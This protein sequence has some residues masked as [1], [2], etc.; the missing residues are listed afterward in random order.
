[1]ENEK[2]VTQ[3]K[4]LSGQLKNHDE[5][6]TSKMESILFKNAQLHDSSLLEESQSTK[7]LSQIER[8]KEIK[9][10]SNQNEYLFKI[11]NFESKVIELE[12]KLKEK[13]IFHETK[14]QKTSQPE[15]RITKSPQRKLSPEKLNSKSHSVYP[16]K[17]GEPLSSRVGDSTQGSKD[18]NEL[19]SKMKVL[20][21]EIQGFLFAMDQK[22]RIIHEQSLL[23]TELQVTI[24]Q[25]KGNSNSLRQRDFS[26]E[27]KS[28]SFIEE[29]RQRIFA[30]EKIIKSK[31]GGAGISLIQSIS[32][33]SDFQGGLTFSEPIRT[34]SKAPLSVSSSENIPPRPL[35][36]TINTT[37]NQQPLREAQDQIRRLEN[38]LKSLQSQVSS[39]SDSP[40]QSSLSTPSS[41][42]QTN[43]VLMNRISVLESTIQSITSQTSSIIQ[44]TSAS[45]SAL[46]TQLLSTQK[47]V[48]LTSSQTTQNSLNLELKKTQSK[49]G[50]LEGMNSEWKLK[51]KETESWATHE[52]RKLKLEEE[53]IK[54]MKGPS[55]R[56][57]DIIQFRFELFL[58]S[59]SP[60]SLFPFL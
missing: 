50:V 20:H 4:N 24:T 9:F 6:W 11:Q 31:L 54:D 49:L 10:I 17:T 13:S 19:E 15:I 58:T 59:F 23:V 5:I 21:H 27:K 42:T 51:W 57:W 56:D 28:G 25:L 41:L 22:D 8:E 36:P 45:S 26:K 48:L 39:S 3:V 44:S 55:F 46:Y 34:H 32:S 1:M 37:S 35:S 38:Q 16:S 53:R 7:R 40:I 18:V 2:L 29:A 60:F 12:K 14:E 33:K 43:Q 47:E 30:L 52:I